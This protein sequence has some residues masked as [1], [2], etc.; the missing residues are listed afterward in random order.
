MT[1]VSQRES[2]DQVCAHGQKQEPTIER[3]TEKRR[4]R[5]EQQHYLDE[6]R[7]NYRTPEETWAPENAD[8]A[9]KMMPKAAPLEK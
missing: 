6:Q 5:R 2:E 3:Q 4:V 1:I 8:L 7:P 9:R